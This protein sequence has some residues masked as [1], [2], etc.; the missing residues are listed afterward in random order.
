M[1]R[2][3]VKISIPVGLLALASV[4]TAAPVAVVQWNSQYVSSDTVRIWADVS[5]TGEPEFHG[6]GGTMFDVLGDD[7][8]AQAIDHDE[9]Q[10]LGRLFQYSGTSQGAASGDDIHGIDE[11]QM[12]LDFNAQHDGSSVLLDFF[13]FEYQITDF[14]PRSVTYT[15]IHDYFKIYTSDS[16]ANVPCT[17]E[18]FGTTFDITTLVPLPTTCALAAGGLGAIMLPR[19][20]AR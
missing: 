10:G 1:H 18:V 14:T 7:A 16:G 19:R 11:F 8:L 13:V 12:P 2:G 3:V 15:S 17:V 9:S 4:A 20:R 6:F 5:I